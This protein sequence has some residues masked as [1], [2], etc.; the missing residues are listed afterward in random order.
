VWNQQ[1][2]EQSTLYIGC[3]ILYI[4]RKF[5]AH[6]Y[7]A[8]HSL[9]MCTTVWSGTYDTLYCLYI[10][11]SMD[12]ATL[13]KGVLYRWST[14]FHIEVWKLRKMSDEKDFWKSELWLPLLLFRQ[15]TKNLLYKYIWQFSARRKNTVFI[16]LWQLTMQCMGIISGRN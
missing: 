10:E 2:L 6:F 4:S 14:N 16:R 12:S 3:I 13:Q 15:K 1:A 7:Y 8:A 11:Y 5:T 9:K